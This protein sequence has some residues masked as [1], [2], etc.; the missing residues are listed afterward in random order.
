MAFD[1]LLD[2]QGRPKY[3]GQSQETS[4][5]RNQPGL[6]IHKESGAQMI[7]QPGPKGVTQA[8]ALVRQGW[9]LAGPVPAPD[10][11]AEMQKA[12]LAATRAEE[13]AEKAEATPA[14][15]ANNDE[16]AKLKEQIAAA[17]KAQQAA[18]KKAADAEA[19]AEKAEANADEALALATA[20]K[21]LDQ[22]TPDE[23]LVTADTEKVEV[24]PE[25]KKDPAKLLAAIQKKR[26]EEGSNK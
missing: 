22:Q 11:L 21:P 2:D 7:T 23:L 24:T 15:A 18:E 3:E 25:L 6:Y 9:E 13:A 19:R 17:E 10:K 20:A 12:Q 1:G 8:D 5:V 26:D 4:G 16:V 14:A